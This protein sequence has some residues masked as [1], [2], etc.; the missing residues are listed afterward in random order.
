MS[1]LL[2]VCITKLILRHFLSHIISVPVCQVTSIANASSH[3]CASPYV[4]L[5]VAVLNVIS[6]ESFGLV[7]Q[8]KVFTTM[9]VM[10]ADSNR[11]CKRIDAHVQELV[12]QQA[13]ESRPQKIAYNG[14][15]R[16]IC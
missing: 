14:H 7:R 11:Y 3:L 1:C 5:S 10:L 8:V 6:T 9:M 12:F 4:C 2:L 15:A 16:Q 13:Q